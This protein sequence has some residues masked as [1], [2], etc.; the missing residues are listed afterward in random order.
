MPK[1]E[2]KFR[3]W[4]REV[5]QKLLFMQLKEKDKKDLT[6]DDYDLKFIMYKIWRGGDYPLYKTVIDGTDETAVQQGLFMTEVPTFTE[7]SHTGEDGT[8]V[9]YTP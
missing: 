6:E 8:D 4:E 3:E 7:K 1:V 9:E 5:T 2:L